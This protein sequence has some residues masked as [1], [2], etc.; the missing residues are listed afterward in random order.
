MK[1]YEVCQLVKN[2]Q[3]D[4]FKELGINVKHYE[5]YNFC[6]LDYDQIEAIKNHPIVNLCRGILIDYDGNVIR[7]SFTRFYNL[8][9]N[10]VD[11]FDFEHSV[12]FEKA[13]GSLMLVYWCESTNQWEIG[14]RGTAFAEGNFAG[15]I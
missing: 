13:D 6:H 12:A 9:E 11:Q 4:V 14:S 8:G 10:G 5:E 1:Y 3:W 7:S 15:V 2:K